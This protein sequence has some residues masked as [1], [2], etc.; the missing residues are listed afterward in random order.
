MP[1]KFFWNPCRAGKKNFEIRAMPRRAGKHFLKSVPCRQKTGTDRTLL[2]LFLLFFWNSTEKM[3][4]CCVFDY[5]CFFKAY[6]NRQFPMEI[7]GCHFVSNRVKLGSISLNFYNF[8]KIVK[9]FFSIL[10]LFLGA[11]RFI[12]TLFI[13]TDH[14]SAYTQPTHFI[15]GRLI[16]IVSIFYLTKTQVRGLCVGGDMASSYKTAR[17]A[18][19]I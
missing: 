18:F 3:C 16:D 2:K 9:L 12:R 19:F 4:L 8:F 10:H 5:F 11:V 15:F 13:R 6:L 1:G 7:D 14:I 17:T